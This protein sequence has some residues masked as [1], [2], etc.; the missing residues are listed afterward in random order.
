MSKLLAIL[1]TLHL[2]LFC[3]SFIWW[4]NK[5]N[6]VLQMWLHMCWIEGN[7]HVPWPTGRGLA[8]ALQDVVS[9]HYLK[10]TLLTL[11]SLW[12]TGSSLVEP[13]VPAC[14]PPSV[15]SVPDAGPCIYP[16]GTSKQMYLLYTH[17]ACWG[18]PEWQLYPPVYQQPPLIWCHLSSFSSS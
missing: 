2:T 9:L 4:E 17:S 8:N 5:L 13:L 10:D 14:T 1:M 11:F 3:R 7:N 6:T 16:F 12:S 15:Y 18:L